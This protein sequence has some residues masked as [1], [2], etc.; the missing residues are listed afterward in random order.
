M[1]KYFEKLTS[2]GQ[3]KE[4]VSNFK[5]EMEILLEKCYLCRNNGLNYYWVNEMDY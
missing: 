4:K 3:K 2:F 5:D 1:N